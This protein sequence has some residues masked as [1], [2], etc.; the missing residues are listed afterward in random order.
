MIKKRSIR[1]AISLF[2]LICF[3][4]VAIPVD[5]FHNHAEEEV[6]CSDYSSH[7]SCQHKLHLSK[8][9]SY[10]FACAIHF[11][12]TFVGTSQSAQVSN[13]PVAKILT[14]YKVTAIVFERLLTFLRGPPSL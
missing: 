1:I 6:V 7:G 5:L 4:A 2:L 14:E 10:C 13:L 9:A 12:K 3:S 8:K 11:D